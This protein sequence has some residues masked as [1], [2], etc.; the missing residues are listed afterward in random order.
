MQQIVKKMVRVNGKKKLLT[1]GIEI[2]ISSDGQFAASGDFKFDGNKGCGQCLEN[3]RALLAVHNLECAK[4]DAIYK[5]WR[6]YHLNHIIP[7]S[8]RQMTILRSRKAQGLPVDYD[9]MCDILAEKGLL[10]D[11]EYQYNGHA[12]CY[13]EAWL[14]EELPPEV[15]A[16]IK[17]IIAMPLE[18]KE[19]QA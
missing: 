8:P 19:A 1:L 15:E 10:E 5:Y 14:K 12:Y 4:L 2:D 16:D 13:G 17:R 3:M 18:I 7:G 9:T 11:A 6:T